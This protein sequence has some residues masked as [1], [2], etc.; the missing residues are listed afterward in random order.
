VIDEGVC[1]VEE[2]QNEE[3]EEEVTMHKIGDPAD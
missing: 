3:A 2:G 1:R